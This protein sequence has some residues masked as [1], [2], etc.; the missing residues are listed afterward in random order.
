MGG[1]TYYQWM[2]AKREWLKNQGE[3]VAQIPYP[4]RDSVVYTR[5][6]TNPFWQKR[7]QRAFDAIPPSIHFTF[8]DDKIVSFIRAAAVQER[9]KEEAFL[10][11]F[12]KNQGGVGAES[13]IDKFNILFQSRAIYE[14]YNKRIKQILDQKQNQK[15]VTFGEKNGATHEMFTGLA[16]NLSSVFLSYFITHFRRRLV[17]NKMPTTYDEFN[18]IVENAAL[19]AS[20]QMARITEDAANEYGWGQEWRPVLEALEHNTTEKAWF[21]NTL[22]EAIGEGNLRD[23]YKSMQGQEKF[24]IKRKDLEGQLKISKQGARIGGSILE[25]VSAILANAF[26]GVSNTDFVMSAKNFGGP[27]VMT[28]VMQLWSTNVD[29]DVS[30]AVN[31]LQELMSGSSSAKMRDVYKRIQGWYDEQGEKMKEL[32]AVY[33][34]AKNKGIGANATN[35]TKTY[36][37]SLEELPEFLGVNGINVGSA[38]DFLSFAYNT[39]R[40]AVR[41]SQRGW[42]EENTLNALKAAAAKIMFDD[43]QSLGQG[44]VNA[45]HMYYLSGKYIPASYIMDAMANAAMQGKINADASL[46]LME[47][48]EDEG[49][50]WADMR[51]EANSD[52]AFKEALWAHWEDEYKKA[53]AAARW[54]VS[55]TLQ[56]KNILAG[57]Y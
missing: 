4:G 32:Y 44:G 47:E 49:P 22:R 28:D 15:N 40:G 5:E 41:E 21:M 12:Y 38:Q 8:D 29:L 35:Y 48:V 11:Q 50:E 17:T 45:I 1:R 20:R 54:S 56:I 16:P 3:R 6:S 34:N 42:F 46:D 37:G 14:D 18:Q 27:T 57:S 25:V 52:A 39:A 43:Y 55:F 13:I 7:R 26:N 51:G 19:G 23:L 24:K 10:N 9:T 31:R 53:Q 2:A 30:G 33:V 36:R